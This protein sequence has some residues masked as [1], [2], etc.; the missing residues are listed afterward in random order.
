MRKTE[1]FSDA[2]R[3]LE[4]RDDADI[5]AAIL[6]AQANGIA[7]VRGAGPALAAAAGAAAECLRQNPAGRIVYGGAGTSARLGVQDGVE[8][9]PTFGWPTERLAYLIAGGP[10]ALTRTAEGA[11]DD[12]E[13]AQA[14]VNSLS[15]GPGDVCVF[16]SASGVTPYAVT[17]CQ[18]ARAAG[19]LTIGIANNPDT[20]LLQAAEHSIVLETGPEPIGGS[21]R[22][23]AGTA[24]KVTLNLIS[25]L[26]MIRMGRVYGGM[27]VDV[28]ASSDKLRER[29]LR[30]VV[31]AAKVDE[32]AARAALAACDQA[33]KPAILVARGLTLDDANT[34]LEAN[35]GDLR[36][37]LAT[38]QG[39]S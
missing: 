26:M 36:H 25:T 28:I 3:D 21:T 9:V 2:F 10:D 1:K 15:V 16:L 38:L 14:D 32:D 19:A 30:I 11:E 5:I 20:S 39:E 12:A 6:D 17:A 8:L 13:Q 7:A 31:E 27:M 37:A 33:V 23:T 24:Q 29:A 4:T 18:A 34:L 35:D 22:M